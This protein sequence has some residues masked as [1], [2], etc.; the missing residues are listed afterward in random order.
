MYIDLI[1]CKRFFE[2]SGLTVGKS[3][4]T[5]IVLNKDL[6]KRVFCSQI[7]LFSSRYVILHNIKYW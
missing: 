4:A 7:T 5:N 6:H 3:D 2:Q 1:I